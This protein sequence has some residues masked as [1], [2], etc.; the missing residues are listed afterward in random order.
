VDI[1]GVT[2]RSAAED[3][4]ISL[5]GMKARVQRGRRRLKEIL[6]E[7]CR[8]EID[9]RGGVMDCEGRQGGDGTCVPG[10]PGKC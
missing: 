2:Q 7:S 1:E 3:E 10:G 4:G 9:R 5:S 6:L 8:I